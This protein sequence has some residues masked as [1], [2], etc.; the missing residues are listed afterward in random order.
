M[1]R[2]RSIVVALVLLVA[3]HAP[4][5]RH[6]EPAAR[7]I[8]RVALRF[9]INDVTLPSPVVDARV[10]GRRTVALLDTGAESHVLSE[11]FART[12]PLKL[13]SSKQTTY[14]AGGRTIEADLVEQAS[15]TIEG[16]KE[17]DHRPV[18]SIDFLPELTKALNVGIVLSPQLIAGPDEATVLDFL[19][20]EL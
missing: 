17:L 12:V 10:D 8:R 5:V 18:L 3:C 2:L 15:I 4:P 6:A 11:W 16:L 7:P 14:D 20:N 9:R 19:H 13:S 1:L